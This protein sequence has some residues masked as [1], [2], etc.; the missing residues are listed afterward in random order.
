[1]LFESTIIYIG[2]NGNKRLKI[3]KV[4]DLIKLPH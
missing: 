3:S 4:L 2:N 1:M